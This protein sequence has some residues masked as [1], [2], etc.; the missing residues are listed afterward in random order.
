M[1]PSVQ[2]IIG[3][4][5]MKRMRGTNHYRIKLVLLKHILIRGELPG[6]LQTKFFSKSSA[7][8]FAGIR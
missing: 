6:I 7:I 4:S 5:E 3:L 8:A 2:R 1:Q